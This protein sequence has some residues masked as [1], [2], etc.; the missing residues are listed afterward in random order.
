MRVVGAQL[1]VRF[2]L[3]AR[4]LQGTEGGGLTGGV[5][6]S[7]QDAPRRTFRVD[8]VALWDFEKHRNR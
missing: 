6:M 7:G 4:C 5:G 1:S 8:R 2:V 3:G